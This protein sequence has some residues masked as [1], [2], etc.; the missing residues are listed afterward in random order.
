MEVVEYDK[1]KHLK[2]IQDW[3]VM[4]DLDMDL[5]KDIPRIGFVAYGNREPICAGFLRLVESDYLILDSLITNP[6]ASAQTRNRSIDLVVRELILKA[7]TL[8]KLKIIANSVDQNT[9]E[10]ST[11][12]GFKVMPHTM[13]ALDLRGDI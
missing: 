2:H 1:E 6:H 5:S 11:K 7:K 13:I 8:G 4:R 9:L 12:H 3:L 10:R